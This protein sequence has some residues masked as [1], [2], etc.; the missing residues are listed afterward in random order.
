M[1]V[2]FEFP[3]SFADSAAVI[4]KRAEIFF[5]K[6]TATFNYWPA[7]LL[8]NEPANPPYQFMLDIWALGNFLSVQ[9]LV[10]NAFPNFIF[11]LLSII[12]HEVNY[13]H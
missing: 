7:I 10:S 12:I 11:V 6:G 13:F 8:K 2:F 3:A 1:Y 5:A 4:R 9:I